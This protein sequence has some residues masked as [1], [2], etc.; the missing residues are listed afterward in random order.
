[1]RKFL[2]FIILITSVSYVYSQNYDLVVTNNGDSI[3][4]YIDSITETHIYFRMKNRER[5]VN[6]Y[7]ENTKIKSFEHNVIDKK[8]Y[9]FESGSTK[10]LGLKKDINSQYDIPKNS[11]ILSNDF[12]FSITLNYER[13]IPIHE[14]VGFMLRIGSGY[15][16]ESGNEL[17]I[18]SQP[19]ML[20][21]N[22]KHFFETG[23]GYYQTFNTSPS[24]FPLI[25]YRYMGIKGLTIKAF[26]K[27]DYYTDKNWIREWG[28]GKVWPGL[29]IG[30]RIWL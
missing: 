25:G 1:M 11:I 9:N 21:G 2:I 3:A 12:L 27:V 10:I 23:V 13:L 18:M 16:A 7:L 24:F 15:T 19:S 26:I 28:Q 5:W 22:S 14:H 6:T 30:Y 17:V 8:A 20:I 29:Q 4:C